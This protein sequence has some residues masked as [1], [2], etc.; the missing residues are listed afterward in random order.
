[1]T[2]NR[3]RQTSVTRGKLTSQL[4]QKEGD[5]G[6]AEGWLKPAPGRKSE[7]A[8]GFRSQVRVP[9]TLHQGEDPNQATN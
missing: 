4:R 8:I 6:P 9:K 3:T 5:G 2:V 1:M 7:T